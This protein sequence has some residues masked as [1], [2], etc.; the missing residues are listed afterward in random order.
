[1]LLSKWC[2]LCARTFVIYAN[3]FRLFCQIGRIG[4][5]WVRMDAC[6]TQPLADPFLF[7][8]FIINGSNLKRFKCI[9]ISSFVLPKKKNCFGNKYLWIIS[10]NIIR[11]KVN[12]VLISGVF[13]YLKH[14]VMFI[15]STINQMSH[16][17]ET[18][19]IAD[20]FFRF[21]MEKIA[22]LF[23]LI[24]LNEHKKQS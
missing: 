4:W 3:Q 8:W 2:D 6:A 24:K 16:I 21:L 7:C 22:I 18:F 14:M 20:V 15:S 17:K 12:V 13:L 11:I 10:S 9:S 1:M 23:I 19:S 5:K